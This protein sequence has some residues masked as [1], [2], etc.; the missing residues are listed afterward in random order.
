MVAYRLDVRSILDGVGGSIRLSDTLTLDGLSVGDSRFTLRSAPEFCITVSNT[1]AEFVATGSVT[2]PVVARCARCLCDFDTEI[3]AEI[4]GIWLRPGA[5][6]LEDEEYTGCVD[7]SGQIDIGVA[8]HA[9]LVV[10]APFAPLHA[11]DCAGL[12]PVC[13]ADL[14][15]GPCG[16]ET[17]SAEVSPSHPFAALKDLYDAPPR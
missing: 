9:A 6:P 10:E 1:G 4:E 16:C 14:N 8:I 11:Q 15:N 7:A 5:E 13:G 2:A 3:H 12:C 17:V